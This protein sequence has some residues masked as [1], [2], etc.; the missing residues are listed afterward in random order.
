MVCKARARAELYEIDERWMVKF[1]LRVLHN[2]LCI[3]SIG[4]AAITLTRASKYQPNA[5]KYSSSV[6]YYVPAVSAHCPSRSS[7]SVANRMILQAIITLIWNA[8]NVVFLLKKRRPVPPTP[9]AVAHLILAAIFVIVGSLATAYCVQGYNGLTVDPYGTKVG[10]G[11]H[12]ITSST[13]TIVTVSP[14]NVDTCP[15]FPDCDAQKAWTMGARQRAMVAIVG[16]L[17]CDLAL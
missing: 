15:A 1:R 4:C 3:A 13:G 8:V 6:L 5:F 11:I 14:A 10:T 12:D 17:F 2:I 7:Q 9:N 16:C